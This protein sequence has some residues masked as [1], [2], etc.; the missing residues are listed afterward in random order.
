MRSVTIMHPPNDE[1]PPENSS[2]EGENIETVLE[3]CECYLD[4]NG[5]NAVPTVDVM[6]SA[7][8]S[9]ATDNTSMNNESGSATGAE[10]SKMSQDVSKERESFYSEEMVQAWLE[11]GFNIKLFPKEKVDAI[12]KEQ[13]QRKIHPKYVTTS[14][15]E[16]AAEK[17]KKISMKRKR[18]SFEETQSFSS[19][20]SNKRLKPD[21]SWC[22][23]PSFIRGIKD[24]FLS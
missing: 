18:V 7:D 22:G 1:S 8:D 12:S 9:S 11:T 13:F 23:L 2:N 17:D 10:D 19:S 5:S 16:L 14:L 20:P 6:E 4:L 15:D 3:I 24:Y 21:W